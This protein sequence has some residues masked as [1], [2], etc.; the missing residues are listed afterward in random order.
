MRRCI[1]PG[2]PSVWQQQALGRL[3][4][5]W[6]T[7]ARTMFYPPYPPPPGGPSYMAWQQFSVSFTFWSTPRFGSICL[8]PSRSRFIFILLH[9][10][11]FFFCITVHLP[12]W[13]WGG[14]CV[15]VWWRWTEPREVEI[16]Q[17]SSWR[18]W[19]CHWVPLGSGLPRWFVISPLFSRQITLFPPSFHQVDHVH[20]LDPRTKHLFGSWSF[21]CLPHVS[22]QHHACLVIF[23][24]TSTS[25]T[26]SPIILCSSWPRRKQPPFFWNFSL[27]FSFWCYLSSDLKMRSPKIRSELHHQYCLNQKTKKF[28]HMQDL[29]WIFFNGQ[30]FMVKKIHQTVIVVLVIAV[31]L[32][33]HHQNF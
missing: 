25:P 3:C 11:R 2:I 7:F 26:R 17:E 28:V 24:F 15:A 30:K 22:I 18:T 14:V 12:T 32:C 10:R 9:I 8:K 19:T 13:D 4:L 6:M 33:D 16:R 23:I 31:S 27:G 20:F 21:S 1:P 29:G 5:V